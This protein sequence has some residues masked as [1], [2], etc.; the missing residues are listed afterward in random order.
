MTRS[1]LQSFDFL[2]AACALMVMAG[3]LYTEM[4]LPQN[5]IIFGMVSFGVEA[6]MGF[7]VLSGCLLS[8][9]DYGTTGNYLRARLVRIMP[10]Y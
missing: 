1:H 4:G 6:V 5:K 2:R 10:N 3:H 8:M 9:R 7:F